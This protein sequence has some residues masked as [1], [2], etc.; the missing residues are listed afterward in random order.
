MHALSRPAELG[1]LVQAL[2]A[3]AQAVT[4]GFSQAESMRVADPKPAEIVA[5]GE[6][7]HPA[8]AEAL[9]PVR[10]RTPAR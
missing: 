9:R 5:G 4:A 3:C 10:E 7:V 6:D 8:L 2:A 1:V